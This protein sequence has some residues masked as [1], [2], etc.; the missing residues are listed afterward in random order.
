MSLQS[1]YVDYDV[2]LDPKFDPIAFANSLVIATNSPNDPEVDLA[3]PTKRLGY[4]LDEVKDR[5]TQLTSTKQDTLITEGSNIKEM[6]KALDPLKPAVENLNTSYAKLQRDIMAPFYQAQHIHG[7]LRR[8]HATTGLLRSLSWFLY[9]IRQVSAIMDPL[10]SVPAATLE[11][12]RTARQANLYAIPDGRLLDR[13]GQT[14]SSLKKLLAIEP[15]LRSV[16]VIRTFESSLLTRYESRLTQHCQNIV[17]F[18]TLTSSSSVPLPSNS[19]ANVDDYDTL[20]AHAA[21]TLA[22]LNPDLLVLA[23]S[24]FVQSQAQ[25]SVTEIGRSLPSLNL[26]IQAFTNALS[27]TAD[28]AKFVGRYENSLKHSVQEDILRNAAE[29]INPSHFT[30]VEKTLVT[31]Y[32]SELGNSIEQRVR[33]FSTNNSNMA[34]TIR[35]KNY[36]STT[37]LIETYT[38]APFQSSTDPVIQ[39]A[40]PDQPTIRQLSRSLVILFR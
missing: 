11:S 23:L 5:I 28:R 29:N 33:E 34:T 24:R 27:T 8:L 15:A 21:N 32:W 1:D 37:S 2:F 18:Y 7:A 19:S 16:Q 3:T 38:V 6:R 31:E 9:L 14:L 13:A 25:A 26:S 30:N 10:A 20:A 35:F 12:P 39:A 4:D 22:M 17:R 36:P 40:S